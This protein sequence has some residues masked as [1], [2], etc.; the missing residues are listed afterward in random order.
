MTLLDSI[1][2]LLRVV[3]PNTER[4]FLDP[5][6]MFFTTSG[7]N[8][9]D[10]IG[11]DQLSRVQWFVYCKPV[12]GDLAWEAML[13]KNSFI[14]KNLPNYEW[15]KQDARYITS[16][17]QILDN[18]DN[19]KYRQWLRKM[20]KDNNYKSDSALLRVRPDTFIA[21]VNHFTQIKATQ[22]VLTTNRPNT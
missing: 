5:L 14:H 1:N 6:P 22:E 8:F 19:K 15:K 20:A 11:F 10:Q 21:R 13:K 2:S 16:F 3:R 9:V 18:Y 12:Y 7:F 17:S 4:I